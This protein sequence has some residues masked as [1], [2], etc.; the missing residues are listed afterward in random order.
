MKAE[1][2]NIT[3]LKNI[4]TRKNRYLIGLIV[5]VLMFAPLGNIFADTVVCVDDSSP[6][7]MMSDSAMD[8]EMDCCADID[9]CKTSCDLSMFSAP[10]LLDGESLVSISKS[11]VR[12]PTHQMD[13]LPFL[14]PP[15]LIRPP[16]SV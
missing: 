12:Y 15:P 14:P 6:M 4:A 9:M 1:L 16:V 10:V 13:F 7:S 5:C 3:H 8:A 11:A 2:M